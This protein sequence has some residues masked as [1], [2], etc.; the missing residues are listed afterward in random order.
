METGDLRP[1]S[2][3]IRH[4]GE[5]IQQ[6]SQSIEPSIEDDARISLRSVLAYLQTRLAEANS[7]RSARVLKEAEDL[8]IQVHQGWLASQQT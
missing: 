1:S 4:A 3:E 7:L 6:L 2:T 8:L 5:L